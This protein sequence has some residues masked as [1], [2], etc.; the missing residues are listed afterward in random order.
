MNLE[1]WKC[2]GGFNSPGRDSIWVSWGWLDRAGTLSL[3]NCYG[4]ITLYATCLSQIYWKTV[5]CI[6]YL[7]HPHYYHK[8]CE[9]SSHSCNSQTPQQQ[10]SKYNMYPP[11]MA[12][13]FEVVIICLKKYG[14]KCLTVI[15]E[16]GTV[17]LEKRGI[18]CL[19]QEQLAIGEDVGVGVAVCLFAPRQGRC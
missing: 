14:V 15:W 12:F 3:W 6:L 5:G 7:D 17:S 18:R 9:Q 8:S 2:K 13:D 19:A 11:D 16:T 10:K 1:T 4:A